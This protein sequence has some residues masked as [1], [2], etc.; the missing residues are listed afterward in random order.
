[1]ARE[2]RS[3]TSS[4]RSCG[5]RIYESVYEA[6]FGPSDCREPRPSGAVS[7]CRDSVCV[8]SVC[9]ERGRERE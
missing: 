6:F 2:R 5:E 8:L 4:G 1:M 3:E 7:I 9:I